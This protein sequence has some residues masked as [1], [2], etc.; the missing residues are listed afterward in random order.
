MQQWKAFTAWPD[1]EAKKGNNC[2][3]QGY[4]T[5]ADQKIPEIP[6]L[7][8]I[9]IKSRFAVLGTSDFTL[10]LLCFILLL[11]LFK[12]FLLFDQILNLRDVIKL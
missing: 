12:Q 4:L 3:H 8:E 1:K 11:L 10:G 2:F 5:N 7:G 6:F 9:V